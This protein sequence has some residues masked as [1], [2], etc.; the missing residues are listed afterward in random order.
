MVSNATAE[1]VYDV[2]ETQQDFTIKYT[3]FGLIIAYLVLIWIVQRK[4]TLNTIPK[5]IFKFVS[6]I[7]IYATIIFLPLFTIMLFRDYQAIQMWTLLLQ[8]YSIV[9]VLIALT[10]IIFGWQKCLH[11]VGIDIEIGE[12]I[13]DTPLKGEAK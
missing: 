4:L 3:I 2:I 11:V 10:L 8:L 9:F 7:Y 12:L 6:N 5:I 1:F 13:Q